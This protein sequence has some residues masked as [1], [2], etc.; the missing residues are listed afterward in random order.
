MIVINALDTTRS[1]RL[2][3]RE[4]ALLVKNFPDK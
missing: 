3:E 1:K 2:D 4:N